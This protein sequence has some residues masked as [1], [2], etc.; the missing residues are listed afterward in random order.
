MVM[1]EKKAET[2]KYWEQRRARGKP[3]TFYLDN[4]ARRLLEE[5]APGPKHLGE[6]INYLIFMEGARRAERIKFLREFNISLMI[7]DPKAFV[8]G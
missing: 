6:M 4:E 3:T 7:E 1:E 2:R 8:C 5:M